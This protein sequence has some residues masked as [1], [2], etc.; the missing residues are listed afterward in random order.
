ML[1]IAPIGSASYYLNL[2]REDYFISGGEPPGRW[3]GQGAQAL[4]LQEESIVSKEDLKAILKGHHPRRPDETLV[5][6]VRNRQSGWDLTFS[7]PKSVTTLWSQADAQAR[8]TIQK[9]QA[10]AVKAAMSYV[11]QVALETRVGHAGLEHQ[12][13]T[14]GFFATFE[15]GT[16]RAMDPQLHTHVLV[17]NLCLGLDGQARTIFS[18]ELYHH[19][20]AAGAIYR[21]ELARQLEQRLGV[22]VYRPT[23]TEGTGQYARQTPEAW[24]EIEGVSEKLREHFSK[25]AAEIR[26]LAAE[27][28]WSSPEVMARLAKATREHKG[29]I[30]RESAFE[31][32][33]AEGAKLGFSGP[34]ANKLLQ[35]A[36][37]QRDQDLSPEERQH[38]EARISAKVKERLDE[39]VAYF[40]ERDVV[41]LVAEES[42]GMG[43]GAADVRG[44]AESVTEQFVVIEDPYSQR[45]YLATREMFEHEQE[46]LEQATQLKEST[47]HTVDGKHVAAAIDQI[48]ATLRKEHGPDASL[49][50]DQIRAIYHLVENP[51][52]L[53]LVQGLAGSGK[54]DLLMA[55]RIAWEKAGYTVIGC[56]ISGKASLGLQ[57]ATG[58]QARSLEKTL[59]LLSR[60]WREKVAGMTGGVAKTAKSNLKGSLKHPGIPPHKFQQFQPDA[61][62]HLALSRK[63]IVV[64]D[65]A[66]MVNT[67]QWHELQRQVA[68][69]GAKLAAVGDRHQI[70]SIGAGGPFNS[71]LDRHEHTQLTDI[72]RQRHEWMRDAL[73]SL[74][75]GDVDYALGLYAEHD[76]F[77]VQETKEA[78]ISQLVSDWNEGRTK[79]HSETLVLTATNED[80]RTLNRRIQMLRGVAGELALGGVK[81]N[82][83][84]TLRAFDRVL[85]TQNADKLGVCNGDLGTIVNIERPRGIMGPAQLHVLLDRKNKLGLFP[86]QKGPLIPLVELPK[87]VTVDLKYYDAL[88]LG[89]AMTVHKAQ[90]ATVEKAFVLGSEVMQDRALT[91][92]QFSRVRDEVRVYLTEGEAGE[93]LNDFLTR[94]QRSREK[95]LAADIELT[96]AERFE[97]EHG[98][99]VTQHR[100]KMAADA[101]QEEQERQRAAHEEQQRQRTGIRI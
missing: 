20:M 100:E 26:Q 47:K 57:N 15:H 3:L 94:A 17:A 84:E 92:T 28:G 13:T 1:S 79:K 8:S 35:A 58:I 27:Y 29:H 97:Q 34:Q 50:N 76:V 90:G 31:L 6:S 11:E 7:A 52:A 10:E 71:L 66:S 65:E 2:A 21:A 62:E 101:Q 41:Q 49:S 40:R 77:D 12:L 87:L 37:S 33:Q 80:A 44:L 39:R 46:L 22:T 30:D 43:M 4:G 51:S 89:Y 72:R 5:R 78:A 86:T 93:G 24:F 54:T 63:T 91:Y 74:V 48:N 75:E 60:G 69:S 23:R 70:Q 18:K 99:E 9:A 73:K 96:E 98:E 55:A 85:F 45:P 81:N 25:R 14:G 19:K 38:A 82:L 59:G 88:Q 56:A 95:D 68:K 61:P 67:H 83:G 16:S 32:W 36:N 42:Q 64:L 53:S